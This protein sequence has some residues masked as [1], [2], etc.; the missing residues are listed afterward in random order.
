MTQERIVKE[1]LDGLAD[2]WKDCEI[3]QEQGLRTS[4]RKDLD[5]CAESFIRM[6][7]PVEAMRENYRVYY[8]GAKAT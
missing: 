8:E 5:S 3:F 1:H 6:I 4:Q 2:D 7:E